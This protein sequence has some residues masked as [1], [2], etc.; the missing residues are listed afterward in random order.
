ME[1]CVVSRHERR[2]DQKA[3]NLRISRVD[4]ISLFQVGVKEVCKPSH[5]VFLAH[6]F[7]H[8]QELHGLSLR[9]INVAMD[10]VSN[11]LD[12]APEGRVRETQAELAI[13]A[14]DDHRHRQTTL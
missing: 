5:G 2:L 4:I 12:D 13:D 1:L 11:F 9:E 8:L 7:E 6:L 14:I 3:L 10:L